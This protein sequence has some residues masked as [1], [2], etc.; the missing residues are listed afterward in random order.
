MSGDAAEEL[1]RSQL[2]RGLRI[3]TLLVAA[4]IALALGGSHLVRSLDVHDH[5]LVQVTS[6][7]ML[8]AVLAG[9][10]ALLVLRRPWGRLRRPAIAV[11]L[12]ASVLSSVTLPD[13][14]TSTTVDWMFG[15]ANFVGLV[16]L[17]DRPLR[18]V[19]AFLATHELIAVLNLVLLHDVTRDAL[20]RLATGSVNVIGVPLCVAV[21]AS[22]VRGIHA[23]A[24]ASRQEIERVRTR[25]AVA[26]EAHRRRQHRFAEIAATSVP[27][28][29]G[30]A[31]GS[32]PPDRPDVQRRCAVEAARM[33]RLFA[34][35]DTVENP[36]L[37]ELRHCADLAD[38]KGVVVEF[39]ARGHW[40]TPP[41]A[42]R[43][44]L[45]DAAL[46]ALATAASWARVTVVGD[47]DLV[48]VSVVADCGDVEVH[49]PASA[50]V[51]VET[52]ATDD[53]MWI[54]ARW[55]PARQG[56]PSRR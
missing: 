6:F 30:L 48:S 27:L 36:L 5:V 53:M 4:V 1:A 15:A 47:A 44:E 29:E 50:D 2:L 12:A 14:Q 32:L 3:A 9:E 33:R 51:R 45:T 55:Q 13:G 25:E 40:P 11:V 54:E 49:D 46:T 18:I 34:E 26:A 37:H 23:A 42:V 20:L 56:T 39:D 24:L 22:A 35:S 28:L 7:V 43:R 52:F 10:A 21:G 8:G 16:V 19:G 17:L 41:L 31:D 38:R